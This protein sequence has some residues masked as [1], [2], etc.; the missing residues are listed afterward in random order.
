MISFE[1]LCKRSTRL[2]E[3]PAVAPAPVRTRPGTPAPAR[4]TPRHPMAPKPGVT[5][6]PKALEQEEDGKLSFADEEIKR[7]KMRKGMR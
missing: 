4:P 5:P 3:A 1:N 6:R 7:Y 2:M